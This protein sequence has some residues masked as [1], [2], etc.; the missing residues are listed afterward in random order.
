MKWSAVRFANSSISVDLPMRRRPRQVT[1]DAVDLFHS[2]PSESRY[3][4]LPM[5]IAILPI[6][7]WET[8]YHFSLHDVN[9]H[10]Y[11][12]SFVSIVVHKLADFADFMVYYMKNRAI[13]APFLSI[14]VWRT[15]TVHLRRWSFRL[16]RIRP[17]YAERRRDLHAPL[18]KRRKSTVE[19][20]AKN[21]GI[22][23]QSAR[24]ER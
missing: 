20:T 8:L 22:V 12:F 6:Q 19:R 18:R 15:E 3:S 4:F 14:L 13:V 24:S 23:H 2:I 5:N 7:L 21:A 16:R 9:F 10:V 1:S 11:Y 17:C